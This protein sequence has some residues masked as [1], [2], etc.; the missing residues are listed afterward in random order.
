M[1]PVLNMI[2]CR[3]CGQKVTENFIKHMKLKHPDIWNV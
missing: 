1:K 2:E 3:Y